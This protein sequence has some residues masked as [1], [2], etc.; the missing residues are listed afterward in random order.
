M[1][2]LFA[3]ASRYLLSGSFLAGIGALLRIVVM[4]FFRGGLSTV[5]AGAVLTI[6]PWIMGVFFSG[7]VNAGAFDVIKKLAPEAMFNTV[8]S[9]SPFG[10][11][12]VKESHLL[13]LFYA[14]VNGSIVGA[15]HRM[16]S[17]SVKSLT[18]P[19]QDS[20]Q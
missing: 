16:A 6:L 17:T 1:G 11:W 15:L 9:A 13:D 7:S 4:F 8:Q 20:Q 2:A 18:T 12:A 14:Y 5:I 10:L 19:N 3:I